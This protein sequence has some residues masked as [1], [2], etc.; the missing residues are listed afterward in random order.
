[1]FYSKCAWLGQDTSCP[2]PALLMGKKGLIVP[3][4]SLGVPT[5][6]L[7]FLSLLHHQSEICFYCSLPFPWLGWSPFRNNPVSNNKCCGCLIPQCHP[8]AVARHRGTDVPFRR[9]QLMFPSTHCSFHCSSARRK[10][11]EGLGT[12][13]QKL[14][15]CAQIGLWLTG[16]YLRF[17]S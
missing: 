11:S 15:I 14:L 16:W 1:M 3:T 7:I 17:L 13:R 12:Q 10:C 6:F 2:S 8:P 9:A 5:L 4:E